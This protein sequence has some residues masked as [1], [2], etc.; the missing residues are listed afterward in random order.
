MTKNG[1]S[2]SKFGELRSGDNS[3]LESLKKRR[4]GYGSV[5]MEIF[6]LLEK[7]EIF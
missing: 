6:E 2:E 5:R 4:E 7:S 3:G 1:S